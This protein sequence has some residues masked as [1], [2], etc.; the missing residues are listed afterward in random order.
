MVWTK[1]HD[2]SVKYAEARTALTN[3]LSR[4]IKSEPE[5]T[6]YDT[7]V[8]DGDCGITLKRGADGKSLGKH[9]AVA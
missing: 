3:G 6:N 9:A 1:T 7:I 2:Q 4:L 8:G 5:I